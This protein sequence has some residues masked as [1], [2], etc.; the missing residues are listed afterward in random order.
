MYIQYACTEYP[1]LDFVLNTNGKKKR[2]SLKFEVHSIMSMDGLSMP[3]VRFGYKNFHH[4][5]LFA[6]GPFASDL[7]IP[8][9]RP[10]WQ[11]FPIP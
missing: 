9:K 1:S 3:T 8:W 7:Q 4:L 11:V 5:S 6:S 10:R 2:S